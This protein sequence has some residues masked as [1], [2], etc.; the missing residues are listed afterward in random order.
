MPESPLPT[1]SRFGLFIEHHLRRG[2]RSRNILFT[3][4]SPKK[5]PHS[6]QQFEPL[7]QAFTTLYWVADGFRC[8]K[9]D[10]HG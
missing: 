2:F 9:F 3:S 8:G 4:F 7:Y 6:L 1:D 10:E 5:N